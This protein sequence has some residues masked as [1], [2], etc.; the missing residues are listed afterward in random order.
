MAGLGKIGLNVQS[1]VFYVINFGIIV[2]VL[3][4]FVYKP[5]LR[6]LDERRRSVEDSLLEAERIKREFAVEAERLEKQKAGSAKALEAELA[7][8]RDT[9]EASA[10]R[11]IEDAHVER[12]RIIEQTRAQVESMQKALETQAED[13]LIARMSEVVEAAVRKEVT[14]ERAVLIIHKLWQQQRHAVVSETKE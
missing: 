12:A 1:L 3:A 10:K 13:E 6:F 5:V 11:V 7:H 8:I 4:R 2:I 9:A 14:G